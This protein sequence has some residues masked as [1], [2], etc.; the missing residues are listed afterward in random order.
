[1]SK[2]VKKKGLGLTYTPP[3]TNRV[4]LRV[5]SVTTWAPL[6]SR[7]TVCCCSRQQFMAKRKKDVDFSSEDSGS[8]FEPT[9][10]NLKRPVVSRRRK[11]RP[12]AAEAARKSSTDK[13]AAASPA[14]E[15]YSTPHSPSRHLISSPD[16]MRLALLEWY[17]GVHEVRGMPWR[18]P[19][20]SSLDADAR[21]Q[22]A[23]EVRCFS[24]HPNCT[25]IVRG[26]R[27]GSRRSCF[28][29]HKS[30]L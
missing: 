6:A 23:Y 28:S 30:P 15:T 10:A 20:D 18:K 1:M 12:A 21:A 25:L 22:R 13:R 16:L 24:G 8:D 26:S 7:C 29:R 3:L 27:S 5:A 19:F 17:S 4:T 9:S 2:V 14:L 11:R